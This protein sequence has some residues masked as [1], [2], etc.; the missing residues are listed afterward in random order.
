MKD[1]SITSKEAGKLGMK[2]L[3]EKYPPEWFAENRKKA[4]EAAK[5]AREK[6]K[7]EQEATQ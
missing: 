1:K 3:K 4:V 2:V 7:R 5:A 6:R